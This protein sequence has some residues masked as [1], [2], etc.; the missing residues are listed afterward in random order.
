MA[1]LSGVMH[2]MSTSKSSVER[3]WVTMMA[4]GIICLAHIAALALSAIERVRYVSTNVTEV[5]MRCCLLE[6]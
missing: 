3:S 5:P 2:S 1:D 6:V 4:N